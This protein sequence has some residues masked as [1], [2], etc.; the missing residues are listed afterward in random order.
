MISAYIK[1]SGKK[2][3]QFG[4]R[5]TVR[6]SGQPKKML[7]LLNEN[8]LTGVVRILKNKFDLIRSLVS[9]LWLGTCRPFSATAPR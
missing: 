9:I 8:P 3:V 2:F 6:N 1:L 5:L 7:F 4:A